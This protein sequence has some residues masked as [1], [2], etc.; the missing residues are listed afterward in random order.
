MKII[1][2]FVVLSFL[3]VFAQAGTINYEDLP[4]DPLI[5]IQFRCAEPT[6]CRKLTP[7]DF[8]SG[9][10]LKVNKGASYTD[11]S[12]KVQV[13]KYDGY[14][15][16]F[17][18]VF[19]SGSDVAQSPDNNYYLCHEGKNIVLDEDLNDLLSPKDPLFETVTLAC[20]YLWVPKKDDP[21][22]DCSQKNLI[23][24]EYPWGCNGGGDTGSYSGGDLGGNLTG[25]LTGGGD[26]G[27][28]L[29]GGLI[30][31]G[32]IGGDLSGGLIGGGDIGGD[33]SGGLIGGGDGSGSTNGN[34]D[35]DDDISP[36]DVPGLMPWTWPW[37]EWF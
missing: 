11:I 33:L 23:T 22:T 28:G 21:I 10:Y 25:T 27:G 17:D 18:D 32:D 14:Y 37:G 3:S 31:G 29:T 19:L 36:I 13:A 1:F 6:E 16:G 9:I 34:Y 15:V 12:N 24:G 30:G 35:D 7:Q 4:D 2:S 8:L 26:I 5:G 20:P